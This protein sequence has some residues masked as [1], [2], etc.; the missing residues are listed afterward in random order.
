ME[1]DVSW[2]LDSCTADQEIPAFM[3]PEVSLQFSLSSVIK[4]YP[5]L[6]EP[7]PQRHTMFP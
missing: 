7:S 4:I 2:K 3:E 6:I 5:E 1:Q